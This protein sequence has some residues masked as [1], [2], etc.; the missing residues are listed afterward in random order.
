MTLNG[1]SYGGGIIGNYGTTTAY[2]TYVKNCYYLE[3]AYTGGIAGTDYSG[4]A[5]KIT[6]LQMAGQRGIYRA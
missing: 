3:G 5:E 1:G 4:S 2:S 6:A